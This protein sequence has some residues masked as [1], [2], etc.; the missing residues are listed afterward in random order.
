MVQQTTA[1]QVGNV[2]VPTDLWKVL[3]SPKQQ[4]AGAYV[5]TNDETREYSTVSVSELEKML[6]VNLLPKL[7]Q[8]VRDGSKKP[9]G[10]KAQPEEDFTLRNF[11]R[12][13]MDAIKR[14]S[15]L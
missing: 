12:S 7:S 14:A 8:Q 1:K 15:Q 11:S 2:L 9:K 3:Y 10:K 5:V 13:I 6:D 4:R